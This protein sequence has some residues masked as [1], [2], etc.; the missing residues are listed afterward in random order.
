MIDHI[1]IDTYCQIEMVNYN[2]DVS[3]LYLYLHGLFHK[4]FHLY[5]LSL[6]V[7]INILFLNIHPKEIHFLY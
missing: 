7:H 4:N 6:L 3:F 5:I 1:V 2:I